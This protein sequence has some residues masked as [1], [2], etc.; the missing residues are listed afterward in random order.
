MI[1]RIDVSLVALWLVGIG[2]PPSVEYRLGDAT[3]GADVSALAGSVGGATVGAMVGAGLVGTGAVTAGVG[4]IAADGDVD[5][6]VAA[7]A[8]T[9]P[10][11]R[12]STM[13]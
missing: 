7:Q 9:K 3:G 13:M 10:T 1:T 5:V 2:V 4:G 6:G 11:A 12:M 8:A